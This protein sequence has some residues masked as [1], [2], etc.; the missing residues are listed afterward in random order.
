MINISAAT[1]KSMSNNDA[2]YQLGKRPSKSK[3]V[4][5][6]DIRL[7]ITLSLPGEVFLLFPSCRK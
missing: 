1:L 7:V 3:D 6:G 2:W 4:V 5:K